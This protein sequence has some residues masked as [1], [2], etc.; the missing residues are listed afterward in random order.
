MIWL[1]SDDPIQPVQTG[2]LLAEAI[3]C[4]Q[5]SG[6]QLLRLFLANNA[7]VHAL[8]AGDIAAA[9]A[10]LEQAAHAARAIGQEDPAVRAN[11]GWVRREEGDLDGARSAFEASLRISRRNGERALISCASLGLACLAADRGEWGRAAMLH[12]VAQAFL[13]R[14]G[15]PW[16]DLEERYRQ[17]SLAAVRAHLGGEQFDRAYA[18]GMTLSTH[19]GLQLS[20]RQ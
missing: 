7:A 15:G 10:H 17:D 16:Q 8:S 3:A 11:L 5:R 13:D 6:N 9:R 12:G 20:Q 1:L 19:E 2:P 4:A 18:K 14:S